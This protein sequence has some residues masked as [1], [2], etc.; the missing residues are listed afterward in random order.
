VHRSALTSAIVVDPLPA[1]VLQVIMHKS[2]STRF[3]HDRTTCSGVREAAIRLAPEA[4][5]ADDASLDQH[6]EDT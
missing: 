6:R 4:D 2:T 3:R 5:S 1:S